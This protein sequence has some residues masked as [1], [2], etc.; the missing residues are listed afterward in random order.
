MEKGVF[1]FVNG[2]IDTMMNS[3]LEK[4]SPERDGQFFGIQLI[5]DELRKFN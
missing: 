1:A 4:L 3:Y 2:N 5:L